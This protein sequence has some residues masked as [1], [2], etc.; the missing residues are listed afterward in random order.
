MSGLKCS[1]EMD[2]YDLTVELYTDKQAFIDA[3]KERY[4]EDIPERELECYGFTSGNQ[5]DRLKYVMIFINLD[6]M[7]EQS[8]A[9]PLGTLAHELFHT[10]NFTSLNIGHT[11]TE[12]DEPMAYFIGHLMRKF[13]PYVMMEYERLYHTNGKRRKNVD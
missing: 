10:V 5:V 1:V 8:V 9:G 3:Y 11:P 12:E 13:S 7:R 4:D 6:V 2:M